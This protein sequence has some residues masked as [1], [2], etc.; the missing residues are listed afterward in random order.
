[1]L[2][3]YKVHL[4]IHWILFNYI[5]DY[6]DKDNMDL[7]ERFNVKKDD[8]PVYL[9]FLQGQDEPIKFTGDAKSS[10]DIKKFLMNKSG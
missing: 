8:Y 9:L 1:M 7:A 6:G 2:L 10:D 4:F 3:I 5:L